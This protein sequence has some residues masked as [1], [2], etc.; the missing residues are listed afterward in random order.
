MASTPPPPS[1]TS[2]RTPG[3]PLHGAGYD[4][5]SPYPT[6]YS[7]RLASKRAGKAKEPVTPSI[8]PS[9]P[10]KM[11]AKSSPRK[12]IGGGD[13][14]LSPPEI[15]ITNASRSN[16]TTTGSNYLTRDL[17]P[18]PRTYDD[19]SVPLP[20]SSSSSSIHAL[21]T[22]AKTPSKKKVSPDL[23][24]TARTLFPPGTMPK[25][26]PGPFSLE[27]F[28]E[29]APG[30]EEITIF[31]DSRDRVPKASTSQDNPFATRAQDATPRTTRSSH[32]ARSTE[33]I[34][35]NL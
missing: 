12:K 10:R 27:S 30:Q 19:E 31:T 17:S 11:Q 25:K 15:S 29:S 24:S 33:A 6:R 7:A 18:A 28:E 2:L 23:S 35:Y 9:S 22:P 1:P 21:P 14:A 3:A 13:R 16:S 26:K 8:C 4:T 34:R 5:Y 20:N 32:R